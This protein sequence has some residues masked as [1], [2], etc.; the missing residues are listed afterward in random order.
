MFFYML[1]EILQRVSCYSTHSATCLARVQRNCRKFAWC[2]RT[3]TVLHSILLCYFHTTSL[4]EGGG[5]GALL[6]GLIGPSWTSPTATPWL[7]TGLNGLTGLKGA[8]S[9]GFSELLGSTMSFT[10]GGGEAG[11]AVAWFEFLNDGSLLREG[12]SGGGL[13]G[14][15]DIE[16]KTKSKSNKQMLV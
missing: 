13:M 15:G 3:F 8:L 2:N 9:G 11:L 1:Q 7:L 14:R 12:G 5:G 16:T 4:P 10:G 6:L